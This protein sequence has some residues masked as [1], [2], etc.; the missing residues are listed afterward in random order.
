MLIM[1]IDI[2]IAS[3]LTVLAWY[4]KILLSGLGCVTRIF[5]IQREG[6]SNIEIIQAVYVQHNQN[7][8]DILDL[9][10]LHTA[11]V[12]AGQG[13]LVFHQAS[14]V[15]PLHLISNNCLYDT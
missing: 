1:D 3:R 9:S 14:C 8:D 11:E 10:V 5:S 2:R 15:T 13:T 12:H 4:H 7:C 6:L